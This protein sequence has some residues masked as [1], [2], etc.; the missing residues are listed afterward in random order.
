[1][2]STTPISLAN[3]TTFNNLS[4]IL[5]EIGEDQRQQATSEAS[6][7]IQSKL[8]QLGRVMTRE[9]AE[10]TM[11][12]NATEAIKEENYLENTIG[13]DTREFQKNS[14]VVFSQQ[15]GNTGVTDSS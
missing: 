11:G 9:T 8:G 1:M 10:D 3:K 2:Q 5:S 4:Y 15:K 13:R 7:L 12:N 14:T 6:Q